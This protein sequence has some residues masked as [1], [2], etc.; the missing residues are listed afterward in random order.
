[1]TASNATDF[2]PM[3]TLRTPSGS[4]ARISTQGAQIMSWT[5]RGRERLFTSPLAVFRPGQAIRGGIPV[6]FPQ[7]GAS[8]PGLRHGFARLLV[9]EPI[10]AAAAPDRA[11]LLLRD[12]ED[13]LR[14]WPYRF[15]AE[16]EV[17]LLEDRLSTSLTVT[18]CDEEDFDFTAALHTYLQV[19]DIEQAALLGLQ[20]RPYIDAADGRRPG[21][22]QG[23][24]LRFAGEVDRIYIDSDHGLILHDAVGA[25]E[26]HSEG[27][28]D[29]VIW[30]PGAELAARLGDLG[31]GNH[32]RFVCV[33]AAS[34]ETSVRLAPGAAWRSRQTLVPIED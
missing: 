11:T 9:W 15:R 7:F 22:Q 19:S 13:S 4:R 34:V 17:Q 16:L 2:P 25:L 8:G 20:G 26:I 18:N 28:A 30:N 27:F 23:A 21:I 12:S 5:H 14:W 1:M 32:A 24:T 6:I 31:P 29:T 3:L 10:A 33:E